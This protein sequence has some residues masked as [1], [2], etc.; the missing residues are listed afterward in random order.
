MTGLL[1]IPKFFNENSVRTIAADSWLACKLGIRLQ[2]INWELLNDSIHYG[3]LNGF[4]HV[5]PRASIAIQDP[6]LE[7]PC[8]I[9]YGRKFGAIEPALQKGDF[10][11]GKS[12]RIREMKVST[13]EQFFSHTVVEGTALWDLLARW[14]KLEKKLHFTSQSFKIVMSQIMRILHADVSVG[15]NNF[16]KKRQR[17]LTL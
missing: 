6:R 17:W 4:R 11:Y 3:R 14:W 2:S 8:Q 12:R 13:A 10:F 5:T 16:S 7:H 1:K 9:D 15:R